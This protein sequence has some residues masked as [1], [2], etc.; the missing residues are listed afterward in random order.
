MSHAV[1]TV[2]ITKLNRIIFESDLPDLHITFKSL[3]YKRQP[4]SVHYQSYCDYV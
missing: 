1:H 4:R 3:E 2:V